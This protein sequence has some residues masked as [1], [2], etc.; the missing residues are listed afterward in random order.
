VAPVR[1][2][3]T[4]V[5]VW[6]SLSADCGKQLF[7]RSHA[8]LQTERAVAIVGIE[9]IVTGLQHHAGSDEHGFVSCAAD[10]EKNPVLTFELNLLI[11]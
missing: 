10:L 6:I 11:V 3:L 4:S 7:E 5:R 8:E 2:H 9:P 1:R